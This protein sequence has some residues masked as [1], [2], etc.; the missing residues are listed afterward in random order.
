MI[1]NNL[2]L[3]ADILVSPFVDALLSAW[4]YVFK[5]A[6]H[7]WNSID[8]M[9]FRIP[10]VILDAGKNC[11]LMLINAFVVPGLCRSL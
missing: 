1:G 9:I 7:K 8:F 3:H 4:L 6:R 10:R 5:F 11:T 2:R